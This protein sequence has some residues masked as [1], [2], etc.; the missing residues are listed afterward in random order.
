MEGTTRIPPKKMKNKNT[1]KKLYPTELCPALG[2]V[3]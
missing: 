2:M 1:E 3:A